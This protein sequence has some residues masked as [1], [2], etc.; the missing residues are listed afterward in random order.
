MAGINTQRLLLCTLVTAVVYFIFDGIVHGAIL[1]AE[2]EAGIVAAGKTVVHDPVSFGYFGLFDLGKGF[3][4]MLFY[5]FARARLGAGPRTAAIAGLVT[6]L[7]VETLPAIAQMPFP[8]YDRM[9]FTKL[10]ALQLVPSVVG[11]VVGAWLYK[12]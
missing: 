1:G 7:A 3:V 11:A 2:Y 9:F 4:A 10:I 8:F 12:E 6:W 5:V